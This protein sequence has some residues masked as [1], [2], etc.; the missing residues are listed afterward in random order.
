MRL[1]FSFSEKKTIFVTISPKNLLFTL[2]HPSDEFFLEVINV[3]L[4]I[5]FQISAFII[6]KSEL[7]FNWNLFFH[8]LEH[9][10]I[11]FIVSTV[12]RAD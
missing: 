4:L 6:V 10:Y 7:V 11:L 3:C 9:L 12:F 1:I 2:C 5:H 8:L